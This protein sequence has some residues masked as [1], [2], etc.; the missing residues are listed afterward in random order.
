MMKT[1]IAI[2]SKIKMQIQT[3]SRFHKSI[4]GCFMQEPVTY[5]VVGFANGEESIIAEGL[6]FESAMNVI[7]TNEHLFENISIAEE[8]IVESKPENFLIV[9]DVNSMLPEL[10]M[11]LDRP[12]KFNEQIVFLGNFICAEKGFYN[13]M[14]Y[15]CTLKKK[16][17]CVFVKGKN[18][19]NL[20]AYITGKE[21]Y[22]GLLP[23]VSALVAAIEEEMSFPLYSLKERFP[24]FYAILDGALDFYENDHYIFVSA[25]MNLSLDGWKQSTPEELFQT[26]EE[27][28]METNETGKRIVFGTVPVQTLRQSVVATPWFN[29]RRDKI[30]I[31]GDCVNGGKLLAL[32]IH[33]DV[34]TFIGIRNI[35]SR[36]KAIQVY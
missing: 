36:K 11:L 20:M 34:S 10:K 32:I 31:N 3:N 21:D 25:G 15:L 9:S 8:K 6:D 1:V 23:E 33:E 28:L 35:E 22:V 27:F 7:Q 2:V 30:C 24:D 29:R 4:G 14:S 17:N 18:E 13:I 26:R 19:H 16:R 5:S 12:K